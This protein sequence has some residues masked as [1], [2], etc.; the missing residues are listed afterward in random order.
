MSNIGEN[1]SWSY[2][3]KPYYIITDHFRIDRKRRIIPSFPCEADI[4]MKVNKARNRYFI[5]ELYLRRLKYAPLYYG[6]SV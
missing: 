6:H 4:S 1:V 5:G 3:A 2:T